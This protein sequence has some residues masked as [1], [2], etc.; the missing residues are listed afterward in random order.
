MPRFPGS[1]PP[2]WLAL[3]SHPHGVVGIL[4]DLSLDEADRSWFS[5]WLGQYNPAEPDGEASYLFFGIGSANFRAAPANGERNPDA[6]SGFGWGL[7]VAEPPD[8]QLST[9]GGILSRARLQ[10]QP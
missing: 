2:H 6:V 10:L 5:E 8:A 9:I 7:E 4:S 1:D 3:V